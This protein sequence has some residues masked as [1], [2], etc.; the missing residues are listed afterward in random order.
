MYTMKRYIIFICC[1]FWCG[2]SLAITNHELADS[3]N[4]WTGFRFS[5]I[6]KVRVNNLKIKGEFIWVYTNKTLSCLSLSEADVICL[7]LKISQWV[8][9]DNLGKVTIYTDDTEIGTLITHRFKPRS[10]EDL[11]AVPNASLLE[12]GLYGQN[13][14]LWP[15]HGIYYN[16]KED[17]WKPQRATMWTTVEDVLTT[18][19]AELV[20]QC[21][22]RAGANVYWPRARFGKDSAAAAIG[23]SGYPHW[24]EGARYWLEYQGLPD[25]IWCPLPHALDDTTSF[26]H[27]SIRKD[28]LEDLRCR[29]VW[30]NWLNEQTPITLAIALHT[31]GYSEKGDSTTIGTLA[32]Y[33][34]VD[35]DLNTFFSNGDSRL[36][37][38]DL[39]DYVQTQLV[40]DV[41]KSWYPQWTRRELQNA[42]YCEARYPTIPTVLLEMFSHKQLADIRLGLDPAFQHTVARAIYK[43]LGRWIHAQVDQ[44]FIVQPLPV[45]SMQIEPHNNHRLRLT[46]E[47][48]TDSIEPSAEPTYFLV[49]MRKNDGQWETVD[50]LSKSSYTWKPQAG[51]R[52]DIRVVAGNSGGQSVAS[53]TLS[54]YM[55]ESSNTPQWAL[56]INAFNR[57]SGPKWF[58]DSTYAGI[59]PGSYSIPDGED[60]I[61]I[62][63]QWEYNR[64]LDWVSDDDCGW[65]MC[66][67]SHLGKRQV[68]NTHDYAA[69]HGSVLARMDISYISANIDALDAIDTSYV[70]VDCVLGK[71]EGAIP[72]IVESYRKQGGRLLVSG[73]YL[74]T[75]PRSSRTGEIEYQDSLYSY[76]TY[77]NEQRLCA[78]DCHAF[79]PTKL[80]RVVARFQDS[81][82]PACVK[83]GHTLLWSVPLDSFKDFEELLQSAYEEIT[84][85]IREH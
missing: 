64:S 78:E 25:S 8:R 17:R 26:S 1:L 68:G 19:Y 77:P 52:Y 27:D 54:A 75:I 84:S 56:I 28:Y 51:V 40:E 83:E 23:C 30:L 5:C 38:R 76:S 18:E 41:R 35:R 4:H 44:P 57:I 34:Q 32:I 59:I 6:P 62:G 20:S 65:G 43:G 47:A 60:G 70:F 53:E 7:R 50:S 85:H 69:R 9:G 72:S 79:V 46:W 3:L 22:E 15:S 13:I 66:Y 2:S 29:G 12:N 55:S 31:D 16:Q 33:S 61:F 48:T 14:A 73:A 21:L 82:L 58:R 10:S 71:E 37:N 49:Q 67:R 74:G 80:Q 42:T 63:E 45:H 36:L 81:G 11:Y 39:A 24:A